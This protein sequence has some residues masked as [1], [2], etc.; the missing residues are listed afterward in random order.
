MGT[1]A[2]AL[3]RA[4]QVKAQLKTKGW[5]I[6]VWNNLGW[7]WSLDHL[8]GHLTLH[9][10]L[11]S[12]TFSTLFSTGDYAHTGSYNWLV[13]GSFKDPNKAIEVQL[14]AAREYVKR[15]AAWVDNLK[16]VS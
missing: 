11:H 13:R 8:D 4:R 2:E 7:H 5:K 12:K 9:E 3:R 15:T 1:K 14:H 6:K 10:C 16:K